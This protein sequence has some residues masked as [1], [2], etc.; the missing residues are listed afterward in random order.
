MTIGQA[1]GERYR[2]TRMLGRGCAGTVYEARDELLHREVAVKLLDRG[3]PDALGAQFLRGARIAAA[4]R[5]E[6]VVRIFDAGRLDD[7]RPFTV[8]ERLVGETLE[9]RVARE[10]RLSPS[11]AVAIAVEVCAAL[12]VVHG[13]G[14]VHRDIKPD[15]LFLERTLDGFTTKLLDFGTARAID[16]LGERDRSPVGT[17]VYLAPE[18]A[19]TPHRVDPRSD[20]R[21]LG[22]VLFELLTGSLPFDGPSVDEIL[23]QVVCLQAPSPGSIVELAPALDAVVRRCLAREAA[24][25]FEDVGVLARALAPHA[26]HRLAALR[27]ERTLRGA[28]R[29]VEARATSGDDP[30]DETPEIELEELPADALVDALP[31]DALGHDAPPA[32]GPTVEAQPIA[33]AEAPLP[34]LR[35]KPAPVDGAGDPRP[36]RRQSGV[37]P[38]LTVPYGTMIDDVR[39]LDDGLAPDGAR[40]TVPYDRRQA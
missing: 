7:G 2:L 39:G 5:D 19:L 9:A 1:V 27:V 21:A 34:L 15:N 18:Q 24:A 33:V 17:P 23:A 13:R 26:P 20:I 28:A 6:H 8:M 3:A 12:A 4:V 30:R 31:G 38:R 11:T 40:L 36:P 16:D 35:R 10:G 37:Q 32:D 29:G 25:R 22:A 14:F